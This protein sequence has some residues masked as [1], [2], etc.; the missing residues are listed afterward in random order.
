LPFK[1]RPGQVVPFAGVMVILFFACGGMGVFKPRPDP[2][3]GGWS[4]SP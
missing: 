3:P 1:F 4:R 2:F